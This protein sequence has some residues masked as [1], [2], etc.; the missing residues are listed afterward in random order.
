M[1]DITNQYLLDQ[2]A[3]MPM[4]QINVHGEPYLQRYHAGT[5]GVVGTME[6][7][8]IWIHRFLSKDGDRHV[9]CHPYEFYT[10]PLHGGYLEEILMPNGNKF[11]RKTE[12]PFIS[13]TGLYSV[14]Y[15]AATGMPIT[16]QLLSDL[17]HVDLY[18]WHRIAELYDD[19]WTLIFV[20]QKRLPAWFF[21]DDDGNLEQMKPSAID[22]YKKYL[23]RGQ[24]P[25]D[26]L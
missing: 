13:S 16:S 14:I 24:N 21:M 23:P 4:K 11:S 19:T 22:W 17:R 12:P 25:G 3:R 8:D 15:A 2:T 26:S 1:N 10:T 6:F 7:Y 20:K 9:H 5:C 18:H